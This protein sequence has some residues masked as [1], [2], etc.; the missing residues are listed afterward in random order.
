MERCNLSTYYTKWFNV[1]A[2]RD[3][4]ETVSMIEDPLPVFQE[5]SPLADDVSLCPANVALLVTL[6]KPLNIQISG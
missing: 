1:S 5:A 2:V 3:S 6:E 4:T